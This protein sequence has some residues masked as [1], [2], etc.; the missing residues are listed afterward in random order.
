VSVAAME[1]SA[2]VEALTMKRSS[3]LM[4][5]ALWRLELCAA[6][7]GMLSVTLA[8]F[9]KMLVSSGGSVPYLWYP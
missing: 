9:Y 3:D 7:H 5:N 2:L 4:G 1:G 8:W 6:A